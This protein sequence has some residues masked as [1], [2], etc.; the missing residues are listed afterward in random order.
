MRESW[1]A[2]AAARG[3][4]VRLRLG[5]TTR[6]GRFVDVDG[7]GAL[8][9]DLEEGGLTAVHRRRAPRR[10]EPLGLGQKAGPI[11]GRG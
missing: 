9:L 1:L 4:L 10:H 5:G 7:D 2:V 6:R 3:D 8:R 11:G